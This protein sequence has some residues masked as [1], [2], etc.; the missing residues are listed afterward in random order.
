MHS[1]CREQFFVANNGEGGGGLDYVPQGILT[2]P[3][4]HNAQL[5]H[6]FFFTK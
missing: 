4:W 6:A 3:N 2:G 5:D 1:V